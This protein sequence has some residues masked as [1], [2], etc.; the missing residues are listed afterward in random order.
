MRLKP[1]SQGR[2][3][4]MTD[5]LLM[6]ILRDRSTFHAFDCIVCKRVMSRH[7]GMSIL[8]YR[9]KTKVTDFYFSLF[10]ACAAVTGL[11]VPSHEDRGAC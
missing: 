10:A 3:I 7:T 4:R 8:A 1:R 9:R 2:L 11:V 5:W 6:H